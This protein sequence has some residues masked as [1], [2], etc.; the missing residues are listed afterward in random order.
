MG[1]TW[2]TDENTCTCHDGWTTGNGTWESYNARL[3]NDDGHP[4]VGAVLWKEENLGGSG[5]L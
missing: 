1:E 3:E 5:P 2:L 4:T